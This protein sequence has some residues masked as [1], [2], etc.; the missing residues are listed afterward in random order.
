MNRTLKNLALL[1]QLK[2]PMLTGRLM[3]TLLSSYTSMIVHPLV[4]T[5]HPALSVHNTY[6]SRYLS[7]PITVIANDRNDHVYTSS[8]NASSEDAV[9]ISKCRF[10]NCRSRIPGGSIYILNSQCKLSI[11]STTFSDSETEMHG[12]AIHATLNEASI[13][14]AEFYHCSTESDCSA[15]TFYLQALG[16]VTVDK[17]LVSENGRDDIGINYGTFVVDGGSPK[18][19][20]MNETNNRLT[21]WSS[22]F[23]FLNEAD[24]KFRLSMCNFINNSQ[25]NGDFISLSRYGDP[26]QFSYSNILG[27]EG[28]PRECLFSATLNAYLLVSKCVISNNA[29]GAL[30]NID[31][32]AVVFLKECLTD[33]EPGAPRTVHNKVCA[34]NV[35]NIPTLPIA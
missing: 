1:H 18:I 7:T 8:V 19:S 10:E 24:S 12:G 20:L 35:K 2:A 30:S 14:N 9:T 15:Q 23:S 33:M 4:Y 13:K 21:G 6:F 3:T 28:S 11:D 5:D 16:D 34:F 32:S 29:Y 27:N 25:S 22:G 26:C 17:V 31:D